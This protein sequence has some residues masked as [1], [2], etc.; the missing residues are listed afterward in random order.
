MDKTILVDK[1]I[2]DGRILIEALDRSKFIVD[3]ALWFYYANS[4]EWRLLL[5]SP[6]VDK[7]GP[8]NSYAVIQSVIED[9]TPRIGISLERISVL[10]PRNDLIRLLRVAI[11]TDRG[12]SGIRFTRNTINGVFIED[13][14][15]YRL[16]GRPRLE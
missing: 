12:I 16:N 8:K 13:A 9:L 3:G 6:L 14:F 4:D 10:S 2:E 5:V 15:I 7:I 11:H 1:D